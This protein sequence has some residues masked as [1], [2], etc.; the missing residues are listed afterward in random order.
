MLTRKLGLALATGAM[1]LGLAA[2]SAGAGPASSQAAQSQAQSA[3]SDLTKQVHYRRWHHRRH[4]PW[5]WGIRRCHTE[6]V[7]WR[8]RWGYRQ[9]DW[10]RRCR[11]H[12]DWY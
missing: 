9:C 12:R 7:C 1:V 3:V 4:F 2:A 6:R 10:V 5:G 8:D 11:P